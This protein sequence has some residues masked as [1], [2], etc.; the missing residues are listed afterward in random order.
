[1]AD[2]EPKDEKPNS[3]APEEK[4]ESP[5]A[6]PDPFSDEAQSALTVSEP[7]VSDED[8]LPAKKEE[9]T[10]GKTEDKEDEGDPQGL[11]DD[12]KTWALLSHLFAL[13]GFIVP[14]FG[15]VIG[16]GI[17]YLVKKDESKFVR[18]HAVQSFTFQLL[19]MVL[20]IV[21][22]VPFIII[23]ILTAGIAMIAWP[24]FILLQLALYAYA[25]YMGM[26]AQKG[27]FNLYPGVGK[28]AYRKVWEED[29]KP[30]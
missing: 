25:V 4:P 19:I 1:M 10:E 15:D 14:L 8:E 5:T 20:K 18:F 30:L 11:T 7:T 24:C 3:P 2:E 17:A 28:W 22:T 6:E 13:G 29:W 26:Q 27:E 9:K 23:V 21:L 12:E 16:P